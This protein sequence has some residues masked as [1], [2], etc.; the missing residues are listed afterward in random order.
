MVINES[1][2]IWMKGER[3]RENEKKS[4]FKVFC[5]NWNKYDIQINSCDEFHNSIFVSVARKCFR[6]RAIKKLCCC[7]WAVWKNR[8]KVHTLR[9][10]RRL[11]L[12]CWYFRPS[13]GRE[14]CESGIFAMNFNCFVPWIET[15]LNRF[16]WK[17]RIDRKSFNVTLEGY[18]CHPF[19]LR[20]FI[21]CR[22]RFSPL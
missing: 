2:N 11:L 3:R 5:W 7:H 18:R 10:L 14:M 12:R 22:N 13:M 9:G 20:Q 4:Q 8:L 17:T 16:M 1:H 19:T 15:A 6:G 21:H